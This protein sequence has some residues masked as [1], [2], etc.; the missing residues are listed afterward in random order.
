MLAP[1]TIKATP[2]IHFGIGCSQQLVN[3]LEEGS[4]RVLLLRGAKGIASAP[5]ADELTRLRIEFEE[6]AIS[7][8][9]SIDNINGLFERFKGTRLDAIIACGGGAVMDSGKALRF[10]LTRQKPLPEKLEMVAADNHSIVSNLPLIAIPTTAGTG[11]EVTANAV[12]QCGNVKK[13]LRGDHLVPDTALVDPGL[14]ASAPKKVVLGAGLDALVQIMEAF[15]SCKATPY[16]DALVTPHLTTVPAALRAA[17]EGQ[18]EDALSVLAWAALFSGLALT[19]GGLGAVHGL[20]SVLGG[21]LKAPHGL[22]CGRLFAPV[23]FI[24]RTRAPRDTLAHSRISRCISILEET[25]ATNGASQD[26]AGFEDWLRAHHV[27][28]L[29]DHG[30]DPSTFGSVAQEAVSASSSTKNAI[31]LTETDFLSVL[32]SAF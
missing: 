9:P 26:L 19:N 13:S 21:Q 22:L 12:L 11:A 20:A 10:C 5:V 32:H 27:P 3:I 8:E 31:P 25:F 30:A 29:R 4:R 15:T 14:L 28:T 16:T 24:N 6:A 23:L 7:G 2:K 17:V 18:Q 1:F